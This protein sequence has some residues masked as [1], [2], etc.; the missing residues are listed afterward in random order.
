MAFRRGRLPNTKPKL[1]RR[2][3]PELPDVFVSREPL[4]FQQQDDRRGAEAQ[5][6]GV[7]RVGRGGVSPG[8]AGMARGQ[9]P[10]IGVGQ[11][12]PFG[13]DP[14]GDASRSHARLPGG[15]LFDF[16][17]KFVHRHPCPAGSRHRRLPHARPSLAR[18]RSGPRMRS[19]RKSAGGRRLT[20]VQAIDLPSSE[21]TREGRPGQTP[22]WPFC[23][24]GLAQRLQGSRRVPELAAPLRQHAPR[25]RPPRPTGETASAA[26]RLSRSSNVASTSQELMSDR[27]AH[28]RSRRVLNTA[29]SS[30]SIMLLKLGI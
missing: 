6:T 23:I 18:A 19:E 16:R 29:L 2:H 15:V 28:R 8:R 21:S 9:W 4:H 3:V 12:G 24:S 25:P 20:A 22:R 11:T 13:L 27:A 7:P 10:P 14:G 26:S 17:R 1:L 5:R 30:N